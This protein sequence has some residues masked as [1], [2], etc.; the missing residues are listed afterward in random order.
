MKITSLV[1]AAFV[2]TAAVP[3]L[4]AG[5]DSS[6]ADNAA[7]LEKVKRSLTS[8]A[9]RLR[10]NFRPGETIRYKVVHLVTVETTIKGT[11]QTAKSRAASTK[12]WQVDEVTEGGEIIF[13][14]QIDSVEMWQKVSGRQAIR[15]NSVTDKTPPPVYKIAAQ[16]VGIPLSVVTMDDQGKII[17]REDM[18]RQRGLGGDRLTVPLPPGMVKVGETWT[19]P[20]VIRVT[21]K[22]G[23]TKKIK[24]RD[25]YRL[26][27]VETGV[28][29]I[30]VKTQILTPVNDPQ[31]KANLVQR[32][33][34]GTIKFDIDAGR[35]L[36]QQLDVDETVIGFRGA[37]SVMKCLGRFTEELLPDDVKSARKPSPPAGRAPSSTTPE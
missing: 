28:A 26:E 25:L 21:L 3:V 29:T 5:E 12:A 1:L 37:N 27:K 19:A 22:N 18:R 9:H 16:S 35:I 14:H 31:V 20:R 33:T 23:N 11:T 8:Q 10:Y 2:A 36:S 24:T 30:S 13:V 15:Y 32:L 4:V 6:A 17:D 34:H 7:K